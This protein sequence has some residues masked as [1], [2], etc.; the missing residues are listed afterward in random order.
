MPRRLAHVMPVRICLGAALLPFAGCATVL[1]GYTQPITLQTE[2]Q[3]ATCDLTRAGQPLGRI[4]TPGSLTIRRGKNDVV[5]TCNRPGS[6]T[7][8]LTL[9]SNFTGTTVGNVVSWG[10]V[11]L[12]VD[13]VNGAD[14]RYRSDVLFA[15][16]PAVP[17]GPSVAAFRNPNIRPT[18]L[19]DRPGPATGVP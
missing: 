5:V 14:Y 1:D 8:E 19:D 7:V 16:P 2:P 10:V 15:M 12:V 6:Q 17:G 13:G 3:G 11:G 4:V 9:A 18:V